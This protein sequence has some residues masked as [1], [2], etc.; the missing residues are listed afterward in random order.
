MRRHVPVARRGSVAR[1]TI[2]LGA[3]VL[4]VLGAAPVRSGKRP[5]S[6]ESRRITEFVAAVNAGTDGAMRQFIEKNFSPAALARMP[7]EPRLRRLRGFAEESAPLQM[8]KPLAPSPEGPGFVAQSQKTGEWFEIRMEL[9][10]GAAR[11]IVSIQIENSDESAMDPEPLL[12]GD[13]DISRSAD[14]YLAKLAGQDGF[15][16]VVLLA[17][18]GEPFF[19]KAYGLAD[20]D[21]KTANTP[22]TRFNI[23]S[24]NKI[25]TQVAIA[26]LASE[27]KLA[28]TDTLRT[29]LPDYPSRAA[30]GPSPVADG[31]T[32]LQ[33]V[34]MSS[35]LGDIFNEKYAAAA[36]RLRT[37]ADFLPLFADEPLLFPPGKG[38]QYSNAG[39]IV[40]GLI[41]ER[42]S[43]QSYHDYVREHVF[44]PAA[45]ASSGPSERDSAETGRA[46]GYTRSAPGGTPGPPAAPHPNVEALPGRSTSAGGGLATARDLL[47]FDNALR[48]GKL[49]PPEWTAWIYS[50]K[51]GPPS[52]GVAAASRGGLGIAGGTEGA[53]AVLQSD[54]RHG[55]AVIVLANMDP[56][57]AER[58]AGKF[59][60]WGRPGGG[61]PG[62]KKPAP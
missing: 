6:V 1:W 8:K 52:A 61:R 14:A 10:R 20:R 56:P 62:A 49:L 54:N 29:R 45:M 43:G 40:L 53:N 44:V 58:V 17:R 26:Q 3:A 31:I 51:S 50:D 15:S 35:G 60:R 28:L 39:Y 7:V 16:G 30:D 18:G 41:I 36:P 19:E 57:I 11:G 5:E 59:V 55:Y 33:L 23:G 4:G 32:I 27:G 34:N 2:L 22:A 21:R 13:T 48:N 47:A 42:A 9:E 25:F 38:R 37:L 12:R 46:I 24:I